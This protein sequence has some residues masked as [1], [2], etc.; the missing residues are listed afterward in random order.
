MEKMSFEEM[1][2]RIKAAPQRTDRVPT[3]LVEC[4]VCRC[5]YHQ[6]TV[7]PCKVQL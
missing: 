6:G 7:H 3:G 5:L 2:S 1:Q 4:A